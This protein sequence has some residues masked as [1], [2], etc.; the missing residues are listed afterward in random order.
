MTNAESH[1]HVT[2]WTEFLPLHRR[3]PIFGYP[4][5][6]MMNAEHW[7][8]FILRYWWKAHSCQHA[9]HIEFRDW[10]KKKTESGQLVTSNQFIIEILFFDFIHIE[11]DRA[12]MFRQIIHNHDCSKLN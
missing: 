1:N 8:E 10:E 6:M 4:I 12:H 5:S 2:E 11:M 9:T 3:D 7:Q